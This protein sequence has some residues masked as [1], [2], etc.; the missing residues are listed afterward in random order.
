MRIAII[1]YGK[2]GKVIEK[3]AIERGNTISA[4]INSKNSI[5]EI[6]S[7]NTDVAIEFTSP[8]T[9]FTNIEYCIK[10]NVP[11]VSGSTGWLDNFSIIETLTQD[12]K[13]AFFYTSN[14]S[15]GVNIFFKLNEFLAKMMNNHP[16][17][18]VDMEEIH[19]TQKLDSPS[20][21]GITLAE[22]IIKNIDSKNNWIDAKSEDNS[23][24]EITSKRIDKV[25]GTHTINYNSSVDSIEIKHT[26]HSRDG[27]ALGAVLAAEWLQNKEG[28]FGMN[29]MI[30]L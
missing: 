11:V 23:S 20:G 3:I 22:E 6:N 13:G 10:N 26:A 25:P 5:E 7:N 27:F 18:N 21:T 16:N 28:V 12:N 9:A 19:H 14:F 17:Y 4:K 15:I 2:M 29:D 24:L 8:E 30:K 1:G